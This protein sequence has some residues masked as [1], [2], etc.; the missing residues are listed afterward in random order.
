MKQLKV[1]VKEVQNL[2][3]K[4]E[5]YLVLFG[6]LDD[7]ACYSSHIYDNLIE[8]NYREPQ[9]IKFEDDLFIPYLKKIVRENKCDD[10]DSLMNTLNEIKQILVE[11]GMNPY[12]FNYDVEETLANG[13]VVSI[14]VFA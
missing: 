10:V 13:V 12:N 4:N 5:V 11:K 8:S 1:R 9:S 6:I 3:N 7:L 2:K 14:A